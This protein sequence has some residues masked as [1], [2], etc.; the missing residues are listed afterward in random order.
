MV[1]AIGCSPIF[2]GFESRSPLLFKMAKIVK[3]AYRELF[4]KVLSGE[5]NFDLRLDDFDAKEGDIL[6]LREIDSDR[7]FTGREIEKEITF[8]MK[9]NN[10]DY[11]SEEEKNKKGFVVMGLK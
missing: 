8:V 1:T 2:P 11:W 5:K 4:E 9:T 7:N 3:K 6:V 10:L